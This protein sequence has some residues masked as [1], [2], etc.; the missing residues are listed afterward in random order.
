MCVARTLPTKLKPKIEEL[1]HGVL[2]KNI[3][4]L[5]QGG[6]EAHAMLKLNMTDLANKASLSCA[7]V[8]L[9]KEFV[10]V[11]RNEKQTK[12]I[13]EIKPLTKILENL[14]EYTK[15]EMENL[16]K[17]FRLNHDE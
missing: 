15:N 13:K 5:L 1:N 6:G 16:I 14:C 4:F 7:G 12:V 8:K 3:G 10:E 9:I 17:T 2:V 11:E